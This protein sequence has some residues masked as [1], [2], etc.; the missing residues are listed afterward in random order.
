[1]MGVA[2]GGRKLSA[3]IRRVSGR[4]GTASRTT[5]DTI[6][7]GYQAMVLLSPRARAPGKN[8]ARH[9]RWRGRFAVLD[10][11]PSLPVAPLRLSRRGGQ[12]D[13]RDSIVR[14]GK[15]SRGTARRVSRDHQPEVNEADIR[16]TLARGIDDPLTRMEAGETG[17][18]AKLT[19]FRERRSRPSL[20]CFG[21]GLRGAG[22]SGDERQEGHEG[23]SGLRQD[24]SNGTIPSRECC[25]KS[26]SAHPF[27]SNS[28]WCMPG[29]DGAKIGQVFV[30]PRDFHAPSGA[31]AGRLT[32][33]VE[34]TG[35]AR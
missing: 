30:L 21:A 15:A 6:F 22:S 9:H 20:P 33:S 12:D 1:M 29:A 32:Q 25:H 8:R 23:R 11:V 27:L 4:E 26:L 35:H 13:D 3:Q 14:S 28:A 18:R 34:R 5:P 16:R 24:R 10:P 31:E 2:L 7:S 19:G 17:A